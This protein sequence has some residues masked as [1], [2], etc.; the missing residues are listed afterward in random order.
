MTGAIRVRGSVHISYSIKLP[1]LY[2]WDHD[3][4]GQFMEAY[5]G[6]YQLEGDSW[7]SWP[8]HCRYTL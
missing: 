2:M 5:V 7:R 8:R 1:E 3:T 4:T 6:G